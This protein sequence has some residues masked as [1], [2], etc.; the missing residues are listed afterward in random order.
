MKKYIDRRNFAEL[1]GRIFA[2]HFSSFI[3]HFCLLSLVFFTGCQ[4]NAAILNSK[5]N[6][7][8]SSNIAP[9]ASSFESDLQ[10]MKTADFDYIYVFRRKD[11][12][13][14][15][16]ED[17]KFVKDN[18]PR[19]TNRFILSDDNKAVIAGSK[20]MFLPQQLKALESRFAVENFS[21]PEG[22]ADKTSQNSGGN[23][24]GNK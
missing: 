13:A 17:K 24:N 8:N 18:S 2:L 15:D 1:I 21:T 16:G 10:T 9:A 23:S 11:G 4:P 12:A 3:F 7:S 19:E 6:V 5:S 14:L 20:Y 22:E